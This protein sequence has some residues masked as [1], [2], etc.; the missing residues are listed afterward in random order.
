MKKKV[1]ATF[2]LILCLAMAFLPALLQA[3]EELVIL[4][5]NDL[6]GV[7]LARLGTLLE[8]QREDHPE[9]VW[10]DAGDLFSGT[11]VS[12]LFKGEAEQKAILALGVDAMAVGNHDFDYGLD[13]LVRS[14]KAGLPWLAAN[15]LM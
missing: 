13:V 10:I 14:Q 9:L 7:S 8:L 3:A 11:P 4:H 1:L 5:T 2:F 12:S 6:H 15:I